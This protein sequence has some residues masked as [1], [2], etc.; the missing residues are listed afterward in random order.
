[1]TR[2]RNLDGRL[3]VCDGF[4][5]PHGHLDARHPRVGP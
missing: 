3:N 4:L 5:I 1:V 2:I